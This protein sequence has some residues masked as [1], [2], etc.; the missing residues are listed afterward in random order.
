[1]VKNDLDIWRDTPVRLLGYANE[2]GESFRYVFPKGVVPSYVVAFAYVLA[3]TQDK[4]RRQY[5]N[6]G[7]KVTRKLYVS[8][9]DCLI[10]QTMASVCVPGFVIHKIVKLTKWGTAGRFGPKGKFIPVAAGLCAIPFIVK[11]IDHGVDLVMDHTVRKI[12]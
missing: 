2:V 11:P 10:W 9:A 7:Q 1:M 5:N 8:T 4:A 6:D 12:M 3:D